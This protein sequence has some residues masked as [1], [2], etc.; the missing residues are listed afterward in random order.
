MKFLCI[1]CDEAMKLKETHGP[2]DGSLSVIFGCPKCGRDIAML[3]NAME[4][5][6]VRSLDVKIGGRSVPAEP[7]EMVRNSLAY[8]NDGALQTETAKESMH[9]NHVPTHPYPSQE[10]ISHQTPV[11][12]ESSGSKCPFTGTVNEAYA[13]AASEIVWTSEAE[14]RLDRIPEFV[15]P[16][17][18][19][20]IEQ[21]ARDKGYAE[22]NA[23]V[24][25]EVKGSLGI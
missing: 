16:M 14:A 18:K 10:G 8:Q 2:D 9:Q 6:M 11:A 15:R 19:K 17:V 3:T 23:A 20:G 22:I 24:M 25:N 5:Q 13:S 1:E 4:T 21:H 12:E 7:M